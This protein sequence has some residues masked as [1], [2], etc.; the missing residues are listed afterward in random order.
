MSNFSRFYPVLATGEDFSTIVRLLYKPWSTIWSTITIIVKSPIFTSWHHLFS[1]FAWLVWITTA[2]FGTKS[3]FFRRI[4]W[5][6]ICILAI[7]LFKINLEYPIRKK[8]IILFSKTNLIFEKKIVST[9]FSYS[10]RHCVIRK[11]PPLQHDR[12]VDTRL[13]HLSTSS[14]RHVQSGISALTHLHPL[15]TLESQKKT[16]LSF[17]FQ[18]L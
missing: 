3:D 1:S 4:Y 10:V 5:I 13:G 12:F 9:I 15:H 6:W 7:L 2:E 8:K 17:I 14:R 18:L 11:I 16:S